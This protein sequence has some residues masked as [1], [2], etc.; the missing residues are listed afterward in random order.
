M[1][2]IFWQIFFF[3]GVLYAQPVAV[4][5]FLARAYENEGGK[6]FFSSFLSPGLQSKPWMEKTGKSAALPSRFWGKASTAV[7][8]SCAGGIA[9]ATGST[10]LRAGSS[11]GS[12][13]QP[14]GTYL[15]A[16]SDPYCIA[17]KE[18]RL[19]ATKQSQPPTVAQVMICGTGLS[20]DSHPIGSQDRSSP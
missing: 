5:L 11:V 8:K 4:C 18:Q 16:S 17:P 10:E 6:R 19:E 12:Q 14:N 15:I 9:A 13:C 3:V 20:S 2:Y 7:H 1:C